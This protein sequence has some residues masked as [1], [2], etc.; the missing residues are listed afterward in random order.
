MSY[1]YMP[2]LY[3]IQP[4]RLESSLK[5]YYLDKPVKFNAHSLN[6]AIHITV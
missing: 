6:T 2:Y 5:M 4:N 1:F 3:N